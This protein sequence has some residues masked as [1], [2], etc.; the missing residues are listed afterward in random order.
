[1]MILSGAGLL[2]GDWNREVGV[3]YAPPSF[4]DVEA[5][6]TATQPTITTTETA[7]AG[8]EYKST[9]VDPIG[10]VIEKL[11]GGK[12]EA[13]PAAGAA[14]R[15]RGKVRR[16]A[17]RR[18]GGHP[19]RQGCRRRGEAGGAQGDAAARRRQ[20]G[21]RRAEE[22]D[23]GLG[24]VDLRRPRGRGRRDVSRHAVRR[25]RRLLRQVGRRLLQLVLQ[26]LQLDSVPAADPR[27]RGGAA[28]ERAC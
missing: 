6:A 2:A 19:R 28:A 13:P 14:G 5:P 25:A 3:N 17:R 8:T 15:G 20:V 16:P 24:D 4:V 1:M 22:D 9:I 26:R 10:D 7:P 21:P 18:D 12:A 23:Q 11:K 27:R